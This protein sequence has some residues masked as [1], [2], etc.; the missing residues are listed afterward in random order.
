MELKLPMLIIEDFCLSSAEK[1]FHKASR[2]LRRERRKG[3]SS[4][5]DQLACGMTGLANNGGS[6]EAR[7]VAAAAVAAAASLSQQA[8]AA[9]PLAGVTGQAM[10]RR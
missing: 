1:R 10:A 6:L 9:L 2:G 7:Q 5:S 4:K 3:T 8:L